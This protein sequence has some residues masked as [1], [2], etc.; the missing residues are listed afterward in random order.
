MKELEHGCDIRD[1]YELS[2]ALREASQYDGLIDMNGLEVSRAKTVLMDIKLCRNIKKSSDL[3]SPEMRKAKLLL[4]DIR[5][6]ER[7]ITTQLLEKEELSASA[8]A[9]APSAS[10][11]SEKARRFSW[12]QEPEDDIHAK[13][14]LNRIPS[15]LSVVSDG[16][17]NYEA[18]SKLSRSATPKRS[19]RY[20]RVRQ[21]KHDLGQ[22]S[23]SRI[24]SR[25]SVMSHDTAPESHIPRSDQ[26]GRA[27]RYERFD[28]NE[29][30]RGHARIEKEEYLLSEQG[31]H[32]HD[33]ISRQ[34]QAGRRVR[35]VRV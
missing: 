16:S 9:V 7:H 11:T 14:F 18:E 26:V 34:E 33:L 12:A 19:M 24:P 6:K 25:L 4:R 22:N 21:L 30:D 31:Q 10:R 1:E 3:H 32:D 27:E 29:H 13:K 35:G 17:E 8:P 20:D 28:L 5:N 23:L 15:R 2:R